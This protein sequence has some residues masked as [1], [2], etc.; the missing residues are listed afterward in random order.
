MWENVYDKFVGGVSSSEEMDY[1]ELL[2]NKIL[3]NN[4]ELNDLN[5]LM[6]AIDGYLKTYNPAATGRSYPILI[7]YGVNNKELAE[8]FELFK[9]IIDH[10]EDGDELYLDITHSFRS[11]PI[12][13]FLMLE[14]IEILKIKNIKIRGLYYGMF[15]YQ[16]ENNGITPIIDLKYLLDISKWIR[17]THEFINFGSGYL[18]SELLSEGNQ[19]EAKLGGHIKNVS[20]LVNINF[21]TEMEKEVRKIN[22]LLNQHSIKVGISAFITPQI[23]NFSER[24]QGLSNRSDFQLEIGKWYFENYR[25]GHGYICIVE[26]IITKMCEVLGKDILDYDQREEAKQKLFNDR[27]LQKDNKD[28]N[29]LSEKLGKVNAIRK[30]IA[31]ASFTRKGSKKDMQS[32]KNDYLNYIRDAQE[33]YKTC[34]RLFD[35]QGIKD[36]ELQMKKERYQKN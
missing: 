1:W 6:T 15:E 31:H 3:N 35:S 32:E 23:K 18:I 17:G 10:L 19:E 13:M 36:I 22:S 34:R 14:F 28:F 9:K 12:F 26:A 20:D 16:H 25:Y 24:F 21:L 8:N 29:R 27:V 5:K 11:I 2:D 33:H 7:K 30:T 4:L